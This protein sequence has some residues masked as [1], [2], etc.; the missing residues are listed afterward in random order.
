MD[1][2]SETTH[3]TAA[4]V[5]R[6]S[7]VNER[8]RRGEL[9]V[10]M[11]D[12]ANIYELA[13]A[14]QHRVRLNVGRWAWQHDFDYSER[15]DPGMPLHV[16]DIPEAEQAECS[17]AAIDRLKT[18]IA[19]LE[20]S[21][22]AADDLVFFN[23]GMAEQNDKLKARIRE[24]AAENA[25]LRALNDELTATNHRLAEQNEKMRELDGDVALLS[26]YADFAE[27]NGLA[28]EFPALAAEVAERRRSRQV[29]VMAAIAASGYETSSVDAFMAELA[30]D[31]DIQRENAAIAA[32][33]RMDIDSGG[34]P[35]S[36]ENPPN[37]LP[38][39]E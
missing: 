34:R 7:D 27:R 23:R 20:S 35:L 36:R 38:E 13:F 31:P 6:L 37:W 21:C 10:C 15:V 30:A 24:L 4:E 18:H 32:E 22:A 3:L 12:G 33:E 1:A 28:G 2:M 25:R 39:D 16:V 26:S 5:A 11:M 8:I 19:A 9:R 29:D 17:P 14:A